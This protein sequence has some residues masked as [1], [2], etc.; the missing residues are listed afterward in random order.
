MVVVHFAKQ[1]EERQNLH[2]HFQQ[3]DSSSPIK[4]ELLYTAKASVSTPK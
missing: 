3:F 1:N 2:N 4:T